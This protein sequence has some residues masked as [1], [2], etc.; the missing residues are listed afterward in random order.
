VTQILYTFQNEYYDKLAAKGYVGGELCQGKNDYGSG[1]IINGLF[2]APKVKYCDLLDDGVLIQKKTFKG[3]F[4]KN[5]ESSHFTTI[6]SGNELKVRCQN[7]GKK[8]SRK[9]L[10]LRMKKLN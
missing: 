8:I 2:L 6:A 5:L 7:H 10:G 4:K 9:V 3:L 1:G